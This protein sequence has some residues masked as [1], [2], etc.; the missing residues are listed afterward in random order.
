MSVVHSV[1]TPE[2]TL[3]ALVLWRNCLRAYANELLLSGCLSERDKREFSESLRLL[4]LDKG[5]G[6]NPPGS[7]DEFQSRT[8][9]SPRVVSDDHPVFNTIALLLTISLSWGTLLTITNR[10]RTANAVRSP[11][12]IDK[13]AEARNWI[14][15]YQGRGFL[16]PTFEPILEFLLQTLDEAETEIRQQNLKLDPAAEAVIATRGWLLEIDN[17]AFTVALP[18]VLRHLVD[19]WESLFRGRPPVDTLDKAW[20]R[21]N[22]VLKPLMDGC[23]SPSAPPWFA[24]I[25]KLL[26]AVTILAEDIPQQ[27]ASVCSRLLN[28]WLDLAPADERESWLLQAIN[29]LVAAL[30]APA[31]VSATVTDQA[32]LA[33]DALLRLCSPHSIHPRVTFEANVPIPD[34]NSLSPAEI[35]LSPVP[36]EHAPPQ[37]FAISCRLDN[38]TPATASE[39]LL[40]IFLPPG[41]SREIIEAWNKVLKLDH[42][43]LNQQFLEVCKKLVRGQ[44]QHSHPSQWLLQRNLT[45]EQIGVREL[46]Q[47]LQ[48][49]R[50][51][52]DEFREFLDCCRLQIFPPI[53]LRSGKSEIPTII[54]DYPNAQERYSRDFGTIRDSLEVIHY[55]FSRQDAAFVVTK[56]MPADYRD[57]YSA[58]NSSGVHAKTATDLIQLMDLER[59]RTSTTTVDILRQLADIVLKTAGQDGGPVHERMLDALRKI[60]RRFNPALTIHPEKFQFGQKLYTE[61][62]RGSGLRCRYQYSQ[63]ERGVILRVS[64]LAVTVADS[65]VPAITVFASAGTATTNFTAAQRAAKSLPPKIRAIQLQDLLESLPEKEATEE[66]RGYGSYHDIYK[67]LWPEDLTIEEVLSLEQDPSLTTA[68]DWFIGAVKERNLF[69]V[70]PARQRE[71]LRDWRKGEDYSPVNENHKAKVVRCMLRPRLQEF[72]TLTTIEMARFYVDED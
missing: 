28:C 12:V 27:H 55:G 56:A 22:D 68:R 52:A 67:L 59:T 60:G 24:L 54:G 14:R 8:A 57:A 18:A 47:R 58:F 23:P 36:T 11:K 19:L 10:V 33:L 70:T 44:N 53:N 37:W 29:F 35:Q 71:S 40:R 48:D 21:I 26:L 64:E 7:P 51:Q 16:E 45:A 39:P 15:R 61:E 6:E 32:R 62:L 69:L 25:H 66:T 17:P 34:L 31:D 4:K 1:K 9:K 43:P 72:N 20:K 2:T 49:G 13:I 3:V 41:N 30:Q 65:A 42:A 5:Q 50:L 38:G 63:R 46:I